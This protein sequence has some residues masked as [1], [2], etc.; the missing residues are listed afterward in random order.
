MSIVLKLLPGH[1]FVIHVKTSWNS[2]S[3]LIHFWKREPG[4]VR[5]K[6][7]VSHRI[8]KKE[9]PSSLIWMGTGKEGIDTTSNE[10][11]EITG[12]N[13]QERLQR[14]DFSKISEVE[15]EERWKHWRRN[16]GRR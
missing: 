12:A 7:S 8:Q 2:I 11:K 9:Q 13:A 10:S 5:T 15:A 14:T 6:V 3:F 4:R 1:Y 16:F